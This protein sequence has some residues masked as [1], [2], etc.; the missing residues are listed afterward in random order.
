MA[1]SVFG[2]RQKTKNWLPMGPGKPWRPADP[3]IQDHEESS[4]G[5]Q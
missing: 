5:H 3:C 2:V 1:I 4:R